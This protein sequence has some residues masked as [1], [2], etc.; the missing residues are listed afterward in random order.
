MSGFPGVLT[1]PHDR[2][3]VDRERKADISE[4]VLDRLQ[5]VQAA[6]LILCLKDPLNYDA[7]MGPYSKT[8]ELGVCLQTLADNGKWL[9][10]TYVFRF[11]PGADGRFPPLPTQSVTEHPPLWLVDTHLLELADHAQQS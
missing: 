8:L 5:I 10:R 1:V 7:P 3:G 2:R 11:D 6:P 4:D 9:S